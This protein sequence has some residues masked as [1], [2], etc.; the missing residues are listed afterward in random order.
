MVINNTVNPMVSTIDFDKDGVQH[1]F[2]KLPYSRDDSAW[3]AIMIP[4]C[5]IKNGEGPTA[6]VT[7][8]NHGDEYEG[9]VA[10]M[11]L[12]NELVPE[13]VQGRVIIIPMMNYPAFKTATR[14]SPID[15]GNMNRSFPGSPTGTVTQKI[16]DYFQN[17]LLPMADYVL[18]FH[19]GGRTLDFIP[20]AA[21]HI[22]P[23]K[24]QQQQCVDAMHA[25]GAPYNMMMLEIDNVGMYD[26]AVENAGKIFVTT[27]LGGGGSSTARS[28]QIAIN[29]CHNFLVH[30]GIKQGELIHCE[31]M[32]LDMPDDDC[33]IA[34]ES[35]GLIEMC[36]DLSAP[37]EKGQLIA[38]VY[39]INSTS[40]KPDLYHAK[41][42]GLL[43]TRHF[44]GL[45]KMGDCVAVVADIVEAN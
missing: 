14:T 45:I 30:A 24:S 23:D 25:F 42:S 22:L 19:S 32:Q 5:Q 18:D 31:S 9:P 16:A 2:L 28:N 39:N 35:E 20:F 29:G 1:G 38:K 40:Q 8:A 37:V 4:V 33:F 3:G 7:G 12:C 13:Q 41:R 27:E 6:L 44:P 34:S 15:K 17:T 36:V 43:V 11:H 26:T 21:A 10:L